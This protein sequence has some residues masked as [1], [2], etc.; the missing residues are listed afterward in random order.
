[1]RKKIT[2]QKGAALVEFALV[3]IPL[4]LLIF[5]IIEF[6]IMLY[7]KQ[8]LT[9]ACRE[10]A[11]VGIVAGVPRVADSVI[12][13]TAM[14]YCQTHMVTFGNKTP[15]TPTVTGYSSNAGFGDILTVQ[16][17]YQYT[18]LYLS[19][20]IGQKTLTTVASMTYE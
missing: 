1:M 3:L 9:N 10:G 16:L 7:D 8:I 11:R 17:T 19:N 4:L 6:G 13:N 20:F 2:S 18:F 5:G 15:P 12:K 14:I